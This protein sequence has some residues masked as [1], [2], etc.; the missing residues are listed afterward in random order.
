ML[1]QELTKLPNVT[2]YGP[3]DETM[4]TSVLSFNVGKVEAGDVV[5]KLQ[6]NGIIFAKRDISRKKVVRASPH[7]FN[8]EYEIQK[9]ID[10][11]K[12][13]Q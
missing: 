3:E 1:R 9:A 2:V 11:I 12:S 5:K 4:R 13:L 8:Q 10:V 6:E 7:F